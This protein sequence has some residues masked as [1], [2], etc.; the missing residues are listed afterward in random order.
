M[1]SRLNGEPAAGLSVS[2]QSG[3]NTVNTAKAVFERM[4]RARELYPDLSFH[5]AADHSH[6]IEHA[7]SDVKTHAM[8]GGFLA[9]LILLFFLRNVRSTL[10]VAL[11]IPVSVISTFALLYLCGYTLN[12]M[13]LG[14]LALTVG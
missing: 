14:G 10:V 9:I 8:I 7:V 11:S 2:K 1:Y 12:T 13:S 6:F 4:E 3:A 5:V